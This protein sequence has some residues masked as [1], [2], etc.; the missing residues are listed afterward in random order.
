[1]KSVQL[2]LDEMLAAA[3]QAARAAGD[4]ARGKIGDAQ[5][6]LKSVGPDGHVEIVT[7]VDAQCQQLIVDSISKQFGGHGFI[8]EEGTGGKIY[9]RR[10]DVSDGDDGVWWI[11]DPIDGTRNYAHGLPHYVV[12]LGA[13]CQGQPIVGVIYEPNTNMLFSAALG[14]PATCNGK[15]IQC[16]EEVLH[17]DS[18]I[19]ISGNVYDYIPGGIKVLMQD[20]VCMNLG[21][22]A[23]H[24]GY[25]ALGAYAAALSW[26]VKLWDIAAGAV[27]A[28]SAGARVYDLAGKDR[29][30]IDCES[31]EGQPLPVVM[32]SGLVQKQ[33]QEIIHN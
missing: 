13:M 7:Q 22:A 11:I 17:A 23:L 19:A 10:P 4:Y 28:E 29:F 30:P 8:G 25:V 1:M 2:L 5:A 18:Q 6:R 3:E 16:L 31:Y 12:S 15:V 24:Y 14:R 9:K 26:N 33:L 32:A 20:H 27:I 21:S